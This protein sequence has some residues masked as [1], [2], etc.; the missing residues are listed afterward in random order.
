MLFSP[1]TE[2]LRATAVVFC[3]Y[4]WYRGQ[5]FEGVAAIIFRV[6]GDLFLWNGDNYRE[7]YPI[8]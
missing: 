5:D 7:V 3:C 2:S 6:E 1:L 8:S 4:C